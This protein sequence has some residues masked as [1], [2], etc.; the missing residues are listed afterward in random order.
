MGI[1]SGL[2]L[3]ER[4]LIS[5][6]GLCTVL[7]LIYLYIWEPKMIQLQNLRDVKVPQSE[8]TLAWVKQALENADDR[9]ATD[10]E[11][12]IEGPLL[13]VIEQT[14][15]KS[16]V[17]ATIRRMQPNQSRS[18]KIWMEEVPFNNWLQWLDLLRLQNVYVDRT[19]IAKTSPGLVRV[20]VTLARY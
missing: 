2:S 20:R 17:R 14:A 12:I 18:V 15:E 11:P 8:Q 5:L 19:S 16:G 3:R 9:A 4:L 6:A 7:M 13:T 10:R 1:F